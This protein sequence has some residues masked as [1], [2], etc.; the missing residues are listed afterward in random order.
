[1]T[2][3]ASTASFDADVYWLR[4]A[5]RTPLKA[6]KT[7][8]QPPGQAPPDPGKC[9]VRLE[10]ANGNTQAVFSQL[11]ADLAG[12]QKFT[13]VT[14]D[15]RTTIPAAG[16]LDAAFAKATANAVR[17]YALL[18]VAALL[19]TVLL[20]LNSGQGRVLS[21]GKS[22]GLLRAA[23]LDTE[24]RTYSLAKLQFYI[25][26]FVIVAGYI[27]L[28][29]ARSL[30]QGAF[31]FAAIPTNLPLLMGISVGTSVASVGVASLAGNKGAGDVD[32]M[33]S[34]LITSGG[35]VAPERLLHLLWTIIGGLAFLFFAFSIPPETINNLPSVPEGFLQLMGI[36]AAGYVAGKV[37]RGPGPNIQGIVID[38]PDP[39]AATPLNPLPI[40]IDGASLATEGA[41]FLMTQT[42]PAVN[43]P[44]TTVRLVLPLRDGSVV[45]ANKMATRIRA[46][47]APLPPDLVFAVNNRYR[48][49][50]VNPDGEKAA[51]EFKVT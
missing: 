14:E 16:A 44:D 30:V 34:D 9:M 27:Y 50:I 21:T 23:F 3:V 1:M 22:V 45:N 48:L 28:T 4:F 40:Q 47:I 8:A 38:K 24:T 7:P 49:T 15:A 6:C 35:V 12:A 26:G 5:G 43:R 19:G 33:P 29:M 37:A 39:N 2:V 51:R 25:W 41:I 18:V 13:I 42:R 31:E 10:R 17:V 11:P 20:L 32:P 46:S 36:S